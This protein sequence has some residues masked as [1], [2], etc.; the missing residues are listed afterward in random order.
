MMKRLGTLGLLLGLLAACAGKNTVAGND[1]TRAEQLDASLP[2]WCEQ[3]CSRLSAC[4]DPKTCDCAGDVCDCSD[5]ST[6]CPDQCQQELARFTT[7]SDQCAAAGERF[8]K[9]IDAV[10]CDEIENT[11][12]CKISEA[13]AKLCP[14]DASD[15]EP[16]SGGPVSG[17]AG[18]A[19]SSPGS[20]GGPTTGGAATAGTSSGGAPGSGGSS[21]SGGA[22][23]GGTGSSGPSVRCA[24]GYGTA[25]AA[26]TGGTP[27]SSAV[28]CE[29]GAAD[30]N[31]GH[32]YDWICV[33]G[34][35]GQL[36]C[37]CFV[38]SQV[39]GSFDPGSDM[40]PSHDIVNVGCNWNVE[41]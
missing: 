21:A 22:A 14:D 41:F 11:N 36:G 26:G 35:Q 34:S 13:E 3:T 19:S 24:S 30:C 32:S 33:R 23:A 25:G 8:K 7:G 29:E 20:A 27:P 10:S 6:A 15:D 37:T 38:D 4:S 16:P 12:G 31:D 9:C 39:T 40:C 2:T 17:T 28:T 1:K 5:F 18:T